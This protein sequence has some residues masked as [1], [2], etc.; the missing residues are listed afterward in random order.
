LNTLQ[1]FPQVFAAFLSKIY[2]LPTPVCYWCS[3]RTS[4]HRFGT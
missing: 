2:V 1:K 3:W 4:L